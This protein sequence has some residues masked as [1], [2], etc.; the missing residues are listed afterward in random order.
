MYVTNKRNPTKPDIF[1]V[2]PAPDPTRWTSTRT[3]PDPMNFYPHPT[4][5]E[6]RQPEPD[7]G[8]GRVSG[9]VGSGRVA[10]LYRA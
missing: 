9:R 2:I 4:R 6:Q 1:L 3:R 5:P 8:S 10:G 7:L